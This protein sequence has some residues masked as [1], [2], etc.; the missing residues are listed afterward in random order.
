MMTVVGPVKFTTWDKMKNQTKAST[1]VVQWIDGKLEMVWP[2][3]LA[4]KSF[5]YP[6]DWLK[7]WG[8]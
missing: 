5:I 4:A 1:Y 6:V 8:Y 3:N 7:Q 2:K